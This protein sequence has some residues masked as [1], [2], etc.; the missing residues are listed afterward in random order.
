MS[1]ESWK[2][3]R[4]AQ[5]DLTRIIEGKEDSEAQEDYDR[6]FRDEEEL[7]RAAT[8]HILED[9][10]EGRRFGL[11]QR[12]NVRHQVAEGLA[13]LEKKN[14]CKVCGKPKP[15]YSK[16]TSAELDA[17]WDLIERASSAL[18]EYIPQA[19]KVAFT[20]VADRTPAEECLL[21][22]CN[23]HLNL[24]VALTTAINDHRDQQD[25]DAREVA[26]DDAADLR[27]GR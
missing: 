14:K 12:E 17:M 1:D 4:R 8:E 13:K 22:N 20:P 5:A 24:R 27:A 7:A 26:A 3:A 18:E 21:L 10:P 2:V 11:S 16:P 15:M 19:W 6:V 25:E 9:R 23:K